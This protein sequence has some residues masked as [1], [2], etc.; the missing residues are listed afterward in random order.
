[1]IRI[2]ENL[3]VMVK[4]IGAAMMERNPKPIQDLA[5]AEAKAGVDYIDI[6]LG[7]ARKE[8]GALM[9]WVVQTVQEVVDTPLYLDTINI[10]AIEA[11]LKVYQNKKGK[12]VINSIM[13]RP[14]SMDSKFPLAQKYNAGVVALLWGPAG[15][16]RDASE[17]GVLAA[18]LMQ[19]ATEFGIPNEDVWIDPIVTPVTSPQS[20]VQV[21]SCVEFMMMF[22]DFQEM[23]PGLRSTCGLSNVSNGAPDHLRPILNQTYMMMLERYGMVGAIVDAFDEELKAFA[24]GSRADLRDL[25]FRTMDGEDVDPAALT[26]EQVNYIKTTKVLMGKILYSDSWLEF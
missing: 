7:P 22:Q 12:A 1:M 8:G 25:V 4:K 18:E 5:I 11:G 13:A 20:Q 9:T 15:L 24:T 26:K 16:P 14:E 2:G 17:R 21:P 10:E 19:K 23:A 3:N 6:N